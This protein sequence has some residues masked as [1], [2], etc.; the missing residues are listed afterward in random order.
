M[1]QKPLLPVEPPRKA[2]VYPHRFVEGGFRDV[3]RERLREIGRLVFP[4]W[5]RWIHAGR[6]GR[7]DADAEG[8]CGAE[9]A[10]PPLPKQSPPG[11]FVLRFSGIVQEAVGVT[12]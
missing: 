6:T 7:T 11:P 2:D 1:L 10:G 12:A 5:K 3:Q 8:R 9:P 4:S